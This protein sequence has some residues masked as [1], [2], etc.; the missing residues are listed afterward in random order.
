MDP[1]VL[2]IILALIAVLATAGAISIIIRIRLRIK[3]DRSN[4]SQS[5]NVVYGDQAGRDIH[6]K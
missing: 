2:R 6:K 5:G 3:N 4:T 1:A